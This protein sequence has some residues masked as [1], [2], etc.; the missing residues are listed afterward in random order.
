[1]TSTGANIR[2]SSVV[3]G[4]RAGSS[5]NVTPVTAPGSNVT[6]AASQAPALGGFNPVQVSGAP[7]TEAPASSPSAASDYGNLPFHFEANF[8]QTDRRV[9]YIGRS[10]AYT[11]YL[12]SD[13]VVFS[14]PPSQATDAYSV[15][16]MQVVGANPNALPTEGQHFDGKVNYF[17]GTD[18]T[19]WYTCIPTLGRVTYSEV[20]A[21]ID[22]VYY[23]SGSAL[24]YDF[25]VKPGANPDS[26]ALNF[27]GADRLEVDGD[28]D[29]L[30]HMGEGTVVQE[31][32]FTYQEINGERKEVAS[33]YV[34][35]GSTVTFA[36]G[37]YDTAKPLIIDPVVMGYST[38]LGAGASDQGFG[39]GVGYTGSAYVTGRTG[40]TD[41]PTTDGVVQP[42]HGSGADAFV[43]RLTPDGSGLVYAT[44]LGG[45]L[46]DYG[47][48]IAIDRSGNA[49]VVGATGS[50]NF[51]VTAGAFQTTNSN[52][53]LD[54]FVAKLSPD[55]TQLLYSTYLGGAAVDQGSGID[56][57]RSTGVAFVTGGTTS[58]DFPTTAGAFQT[59]HGGGA[60]AFLTALNPAGTGVVYSTFIGGSDEDRGSALVTD[61]LNRVGIAGQTRST[62]FPVT[63]GAPQ[64]AFAGGNFDAFALRMKPDGS[65]LL[66][67]TYL[68]GAGDDRGTGIATTGVG[69]TYV[70]GW[71]GSTAF[72]VTAGA[73]QT[74]YGGGASDAFAASIPLNGKS[75]TY[76][77][78]IGGA[79]GD[80]G[81]SVV[82]DSSGRAY[83][84]GFGAT[85]YPVT[86][87]A[88]QGTFGGGSSDAILTQL[89]SN[90]ASLLYST[91]HGGGAVDIGNSIAIDRLGHIYITGNTLSSNL[92][93]SPSG[94]QKVKG[95]SDDSFIIKYTISAGERLTSRLPTPARVSKAPSN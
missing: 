23:G 31:K 16:R 68:G 71:T 72:P 47:Q 28:G 67:A 82:I 81:N 11:V 35:D 92:P 79:G 10:S 50:L 89:A 46:D 33:G 80:R 9:D 60:D 95:G 59:T 54:A 74:T 17:L 88:L 30:L 37:D 90:G 63:P 42:D 51:P 75:L 61:G 14:L 66:Y 48:A 64:G 65:G 29:L 25:V 22:A 6:F 40:S 7:R 70:T 85:G 38:Y 15:L 12:N 39:V 83:I 8:G 41:F 94:F 78:F 19:Q 45:S 57:N 2:R 27:E 44:Y 77:T 36:I 21:G 56:I 58:T 5:I 55:G 24:E 93:V 69:Q 53:T 4:T 84:T 76:S 62:N 86:G 73:Y 43:A 34:V 3:V 26:I 20:Y 13:E 91:F 1:M 52:N 32:P 87:D 18:P 49:Y